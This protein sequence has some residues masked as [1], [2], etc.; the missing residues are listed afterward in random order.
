MGIR[1]SLFLLLLSGMVIKTVPAQSFGPP[2]TGE[3]LYQLQEREG[4][5]HLS[6]ASYAAWWSNP[7]LHRVSRS[8]PGFGRSGS[9][10]THQLVQMGET[11]T[12][13]LLEATYTLGQRW[14]VG[15]WYNP[16]RGE[17]VREVLRSGG[18]SVMSDFVRD[19]DMAD[20]YVSYYGERGFSAQVGYQRQHENIQGRRFSSALHPTLVSWNVWLT[21]RV[22][23]RADCFLITPF[24]SAGYY[25]ASSFDYSLSAL[26]GLAIT[27]D[28]R[29]S[30]STSAW[31]F[32]VLR[33]SPPLRLTGGLV[34]RF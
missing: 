2:L 11:T 12:S 10:Q 33:S 17:R 15:G 3:V 18:G 14:S 20:V 13:L 6:L 21:Q 4:T 31:W 25:P 28:E 34:Y 32:G 8:L 29:L 24:V 7:V 9:P 19:I 5:T 27:F 22:D 1:N 16:I 23:G 26:V 30:L